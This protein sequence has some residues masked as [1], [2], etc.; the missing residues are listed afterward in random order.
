MCGFVGFHTPRGFPANAGELARNMGARLRHRGPD[1]SGEW[2]EPALGTALAFRR[3]SIIDLSEFGHQPMV[4]QDGR[5]VLMLNGEIYNH[6][7]L[8]AELEQQGHSFRGHSDTEVLLAG[9]SAWGLE[10]TLKRCAGMFALALVDVRERQLQLARDRLGEKPLYYGWSGGH[11]FFGSELKAFRPHPGFVP[12]VE[13]R[14]LTLYLRFAY[15][16]SPWCI[17]A[18]FHKLAAGHIL[19]LP[20]DG[21]AG[22]GKETLRPYWTLPRPDENGTFNGSPEDCVRQLEEL[23]RGSIRL[24]MLAD[25]PVGAF[26]SGGIDSSTVVSLMQAQATRPV[27]TFS[28]GFP[29]AHFDE[30]GH[31]E[32]VA[33]HLGTE[34]VTWRCTDAELLDLANQVPR[35][36]CEPFA[37]DSQLPTM[38]LARL[39]RQQVTV[40]LSGD[41]G[42]ELFH[43]YGHYEKSL[44]RWQEMRRFPP[45][46]TVARCAIGAASAVVSLLGESPFK[47]QWT[48][49]LGKA[50]NQWL[51]DNLPG[52]YRHR[53]SL[54]KAPDLYLSKPEA[55]RDFFDETPRMAKEDEA[56]L[57]YVDLNTYLP[58]DILV[59]VD[60]AAMAFSLET[61]IPLLD[62]RIVEYATRIPSALKRHN[63]KAKWP[64]R[65]IL[66][67]RVPPALTERPKM[68]FCTPMGR[69]LRGPLFEW[70]EGL[71]GAERL[72]R[73][74]FFDAEAV[75]RLWAQHQHGPRDGGLLLWGLLMFQAWHDTF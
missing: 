21:S 22:P 67:R 36:Y 13:R 59:K 10:A 48:S 27:K 69:W 15:V 23:I 35:V 29:D 2:I 33:K 66:E 75:R 32:K 5:F 7:A 41:G 1:D 55:A 16:P 50:R 56:W 58:D 52:Y 18:G 71:L 53:M 70:A 54:H 61:R 20:L 19:S 47:R 64:L 17:L 68:G 40:C 28:I 34:H 73:E 46:R 12:E 62:H 42:D 72:R 43:G 4:S 6:V 49:R 9:S 8:R 74:G 45:L 37:D 26:L 24:Q 39:A 60:R 14:A 57:S 3:L 51:S 63:G 11:F 65:A 44:R 31:A 38:A 25:V 30:S